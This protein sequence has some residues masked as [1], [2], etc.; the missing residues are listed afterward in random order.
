MDLLTI[1]DSHG[2]YNLRGLSL[3]LF[4]RP[5]CPYRLVSSS[6][7]VVSVSGGMWV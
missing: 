3:S 1:T 2:A 7:L 5:P 4:T 6:V